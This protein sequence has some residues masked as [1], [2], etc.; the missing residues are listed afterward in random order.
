MSFFWYVPTG[1][2]TTC[3]SAIISCLVFGVNDIDEFDVRL[4]TPS[5]RK[6]FIQTRVT[7]PIEEDIDER[8]ALNSIVKN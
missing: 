2:L 3:I 1:A 7:L 8:V 4:L 5:L 6:F